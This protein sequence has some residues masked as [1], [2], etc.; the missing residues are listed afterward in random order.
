MNNLTIFL[1][2][3]QRENLGLVKKYS[4][5]EIFYPTNHNFLTDGEGWYFFANPPPHTHAHTHTHTKTPPALVPTVWSLKKQQQQKQK[6]YTRNRYM[7]GIRRIPQCTFHY[8]PVCFYS[9]TEYWISNMLRAEKGQTERRIYRKIIWIQ[10]NNF[11][12]LISVNAHSKT[13]SFKS[14]SVFIK[15]V[16]Y[17]ISS[18]TSK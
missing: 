16:Y 8:I 11:I 12:N 2:Q 3:R 4:R 14:L 18:F 7:E 6:V 10:K 13:F 17:R 5:S 1:I 9:E 15:N